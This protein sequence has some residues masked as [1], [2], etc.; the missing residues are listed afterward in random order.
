MQTPKEPSVPIEAYQQILAENAELKAR[1]AWF[2]RQIFGAK[3]ERF[4]PDIPGQLPLNFGAAP[5]A[6]VLESVLAE[7]Q[8]QRQIAAHQRS[9]PKPN[10]N[11]QGRT[12]LP[13]H[14]P[15]VEEVIEPEAELEGL[16]RIGEDVTEVLEMEVGKLWVRRIVRP[17]YV[18][19]QALQAQVEQQAEEKGEVP[20]GS[21]LQAP[22]PDRP[23]PRYKAGV[24]MMVY[25]LIAKF[26][27]HLPLYRISKQ[28]ARQGVKIPDSTLGQ[29]VQAAADA[30]EPLYEAYEKLIFKTPYLQMDETR[31]KVL[32][33][34]KKG[35][36]HLG[37]LWAVFDPVNK[38]PFFFYQKGRD[39]Q[40]PKE[41]LEHFAGV[42]QCDGYSVYETLNNKLKNIVLLNC[43]AHIRRKF[44]EARDNDK[45]RA[46]EALTIIGALYAI[47][48]QARTQQLNPQQRLQ[49]RLEKAKPIADAFAQWI[50]E[51]YLQVLPQSKIGKAFAY[52]INRWENMPL[53]L[54]DGQLE[55]DNNL[56]ENIIRPAA[57]GRKNYLFAGS[58]DA[59]KR[60]AMLY[61]FFAA[62]KHQN[63]NPEEWL[64]DV[65]N[66]IHLQPINKIDEL[67]PH[68]WKAQNRD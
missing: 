47:E 3:T 41:R 19:P 35:K 37:W 38:R 34:G 67:L 10:Q 9:V 56:V 61:T 29:W 23:F 43:L 36:C 16:K 21:V 55:I 54:T 11:H 32:E 15:R 51:Q 27:D 14:L 17:R 48:E 49:L 68:N 28:F 20:P 6:G 25:L 66:R 13:G 50:K 31:L 4:V 26:V 33:E 57:I 30:L 62:C 24:S 39:H 58:H 59:A 22:A 42:L 44:F 7:Q 12:E 64:N 63:I 53:Y 2:E 45:K 60:I 65:L 8:A 1:L 46:D 40:G 5:I 18:R 52:A